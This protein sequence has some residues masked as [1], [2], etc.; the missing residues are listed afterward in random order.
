MKLRHRPSPMA[1]Q[2]GSSE[3]KGRKESSGEFHQTGR[4]QLHPVLT[5]QMHVARLSTIDQPNSDSHRSSPLITTTQPQTNFTSSP[6]RPFQSNLTTTI[7]Q[8]TNST[9][10]NQP[11]PYKLQP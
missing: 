5:L 2:S 8:H 1:T 3:M 6:T 9:I 10:I 11:K 4:W 7:T